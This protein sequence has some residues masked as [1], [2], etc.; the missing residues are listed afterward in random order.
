MVQVSRVAQWRFAD[1]ATEA[2]DDASPSNRRNVDVMDEPVSLKWRPGLTRAEAKARAKEMRKYIAERSERREASRAQANQ[3]RGPHPG[4]SEGDDAAN[5]TK[6]AEVRGG[7]TEVSGAV[8]RSPVP[9][10]PTTNSPLYERLPSELRSRVLS[11]LDV[12]GLICAAGSSHGTRKLAAEAALWMAAHEQLFGPAETLPD[13]WQ[14]GCRAS[15]GSAREGC[16][17]SEAALDAWRR[18]MAC[19][20][21]LAGMTAV[22]LAGAVGASIHD[23]R[24]VRL[25]EVSSGR[26]LAAHHPKH[27]KHELTCCET[28]GTRLVVGDS[29]GG[30]HVYDMEELLP[31]PPVSVL[32]DDQR[33]GGGGCGVC[34]TL[35]WPSLTLAATHSGSLAGLE[36][37]ERSQAAL[38]RLQLGAGLSGLAH[39]GGAAFYAA[40]GGQ[41]W[42]CDAERGAVVSSAG[43]AS[44]DLDGLL[45]RMALQPTAARG[46][47]FSVGWRLL[48]AADGGTVHL[49]DMREP[50]AKCVCSAAMPAGSGVGSVHIDPGGEGWPGHLL[51]STSSS[52]VL[53]FD[54]RR[55]RAGRAPHV[56]R[57]TPPHSEKLAPCAA[58][59]VSDGVLVAPGGAKSSCALR[60]TPRRLG[61]TAPNM[62]AAEERGGRNSKG[63]REKPRP[64]RQ[65]KKQWSH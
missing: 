61:E 21:P 62:D 48:A 53:V 4:R 63:R 8:P 15:S 14:S 33:P 1:E 13:K 38:W 2:G 50:N 20:L 28:D 40:A 56:G 22:C 49:F 23:G 35:L 65:T 43:A 45:R 46:V 60:F 30:L 58:F 25:W 44:G 59:A 37:V 24:M 10:A 64:A 29:G 5:S 17:A 42:H 51:A 47:D 11:H 6:A 32:G 26:R 54:V 36:Q 52:S 31:T 3:A 9:R 16:S 41:V 12:R 19:E 34:A 27:V 55:V 57:L 7:G 18:A 39:G